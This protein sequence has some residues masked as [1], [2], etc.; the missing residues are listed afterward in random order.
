MNFKVK[1]QLDGRGVYY[2]PNEPIMLDSLLVHFMAI[3]QGKSRPLQR[4]ETPDDI[5]IPLMQETIQGRTLWK[6]SAFFPVGEQFES[7]Q[8]W[9]KKFNLDSIE[10]TDGSPNLTNGVY[11]EYN[12]PFPLLVC[13]E[14]VAY[15]SGNRHNV[16][17]I[18]RKNLKH[19]G[20]KRSQ[21]KGGVV[22]ITTCGIKEDWSWIKDGCA[23]RFLPV[24]DHYARKVRLKPPYWNIVDAV[25]CCEIGE[26]YQL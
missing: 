16:E 17:R 6:A 14:L 25:H 22:K 3:I 11:R 13:R 23:T 21:G 7:L 9:R 12:M 20:K 1:I 18:L 15:A 10:F 4:D 5:Q 8:F 2:D 24:D 19:L 26:E